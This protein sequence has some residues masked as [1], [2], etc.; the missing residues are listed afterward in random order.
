MPVALSSYRLSFI[1]LLVFRSRRSL[2]GSVLIIR[3]KATVQT[4]SL[5][6]IEYNE[7]WKNIFPVTLKKLWDIFSVLAY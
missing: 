2:E 6:H 7:V 4:L 1:R 5:I 3:C